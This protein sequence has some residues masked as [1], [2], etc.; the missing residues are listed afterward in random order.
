MNP[1]DAI[2]EFQDADFLP[3]PYDGSG[4]DRNW[5]PLLEDAF[6]ADFLKE[7]N[8]LYAFDRALHL[9]GVDPARPYHDL[10]VRN[11][12]SAL[13]RGSYGDMLKD[14]CFFAEDLFGHLFGLRGPEAV[15][16]DPESGNLDTLAEGFDGW[17]R[18]IGE[19]TDYATGQSL[20][21]AWSEEKDVIPF[22][23]R[24]APRTPFIL[25]GEFELDNLRP[26]GW[27]ENQEFMAEVYEKVKDLPEGSEIEIDAL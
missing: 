22:D 27:L 6:Y 18:F 24:L 5:S 3:T 23:S 8:G 13:W 20:S 26:L 15:V 14:V 9:F 11:A 10:S 21:Q 2:L 4:Q 16:F 25:G 17:L 7:Y 12:P 1:L 19:D